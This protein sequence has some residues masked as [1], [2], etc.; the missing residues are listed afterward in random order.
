MRITSRPNPTVGITASSISS[1][2]S[3]MRNSAR[4]ARTARLLQ[5]R[6]W[7]RRLWTSRSKMRQVGGE[8]KR[9]LAKPR[10]TG[11]TRAKFAKNSKCEGRTKGSLFAPTAVGSLTSRAS[12]A[13]CGICRKKEPIGLALIV[14]AKWMPPSTP[15]AVPS[16]A[17]QIESLTSLMLGSACSSTTSGSKTPILLLLFLPPPPP[18]PLTQFEN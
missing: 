16:A 2:P 5:G 7:R 4:R 17:K 14:C 12:S 15:A 10:V 13:G 1:P 3:L 11:M 18:P 9:G 8:K 6:V